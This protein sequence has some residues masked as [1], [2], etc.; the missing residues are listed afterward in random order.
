MSDD[1][2]EL[3]KSEAGAAAGPRGGVL[4]RAEI[5]RLI[6]GEP[7][8]LAGLRDPAAQLQPNGVD[9]TLERLWA[10]EGPLR[11]G[12]SDGARALP[13]RRAL[14]FDADGWL[15]LAPGAYVALIA[16]TVQLPLDLMA[17]AR[18][19]STLLRGGVSVHTA[20]WDA[21]YVGRSELLLVVHNAAGFV[22]Q[23]GARI[24]Q[25]I[26]CRLEAP[27]VGYRGRYQGEHR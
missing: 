20:V 11:L 24:A 12:Q 2:D 21:G 27:T 22:V 9:L 3:Q 18:P 25:I 14:E 19:R 1:L 4:D 15:R 10:L 7:P 17:L 5:E 16:E 23:R 26:F 8:L 6:R 13:E